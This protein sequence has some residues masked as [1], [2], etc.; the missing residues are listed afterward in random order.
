ME[1]TPS[2]LTT[3]SQDSASARRVWLECGALAFLLAL[4]AAMRIPGLLQGFWGDELYTLWRA[5]WPMDKLLSGKMGSGVFTLLT[6]LVVKATMALFPPSAQF[7]FPAQMPV[8]YEVLPMHLDE[9]TLRLPFFFISLI[10]L[11]VLFR[12]VRKYFGLNAAF[13]A[14]LFLAVSPEH[15]LYSTELRFYGMVC[16][17][18]AVLL[19]GVQSVLDGKGPRGWVITALGLLLGLSTHLSFLFVTAGIMGGAAVSLLFDASPWRRRTVM[20]AALAGLC[21]AVVAVQVA[22]TVSFSPA[23]LGAV[24]GLFG[25]EDTAAADPAQ[26]VEGPAPADRAGERPAQKYTLEPGGYFNSFIAQRYLSCHGLLCGIALA[27]VL[28]AGFAGLYARRRSMLFM[29]LGVLC[30]PLPL[31]FVQVSH[32]WLYRYFIFDILLCAVLVGVGMDTLFRVLRRLAGASR[33]RLGLAACAALAALAVLAYLPSLA[34]GREAAPDS[35]ADG[36]MR[37]VAETLA[38]TMMPTDRILVLE[39]Y[40]LRLSHHLIPYH[41]RRMRP[42]WQLR[43]EIN[44]MQICADAAAFKEML[45][46]QPRDGFWVVSFDD[47]N[48][49]ATLNG[50]VRDAGAQLRGQ[51]SNS[52]LWHIGGDAQRQPNLL[53]EGVPGVELPKEGAAIAGGAYR[54]ALLENAEQALKTPTVLF[55][56]VRDE[57]GQ[58]ATGLQANRGYT[59]RF[60][61]QLEKVLPGSN[62]TRTFRVMLF[63]K[64]GTTDLMYAEGT[65]ESQEYT[66]NF[67]PGEYLPETLSNVKIGFGIRGGTGAFRVENVTLQSG[68]IPSR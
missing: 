19:Y 43:G 44:K 13:W 42:D 68:A 23:S 27:V 55:P 37:R 66:V 62:R 57:S 3:E 8:S 28:A 61:L 29:V 6:Y 60:R 48:R 47:N 53:A 4:A 33:P 45:A 15:A 5:M 38:A 18:G 51:Y 64:E 26:D 17:A 9:L 31:F 2:F 14:G 59:L 56:V 7:R 54:V 1:K 30:A 34:A 36:G 40:K 12:M 32:K 49:D 11:I 63:A 41:L 39:P 25:G 24:A 20:V 46:K 67:A 16:L 10:T 50:V 21:V 35:H 22:V 52:S 58:P 65:T